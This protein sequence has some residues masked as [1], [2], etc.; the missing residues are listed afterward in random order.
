MASLAEKFPSIAA[1]WDFEKNGDLTPDKV[2]SGSHVDVYW[3]CPVCGQSYKARVCNRTSPSKQKKSNKCPVCLGHVIIPGYNSLKAKFPEIIKREWDYELNKVDPDTIAPHTNKAYY[4]KCNKGHESY[5]SKVNNK[6]NGNGGNCPRCSHQKLSPEFSLQTLRPDLSNEW[7]V[8]A[9]CGITPD[10]VSAYANKSV[11]WVCSKCGHK[12][13]ADIDNRSNGR[14]CP[15]CAKGHHTSFPEQVVFHFI[16]KAFPDAINGYKIDGKEIDVFIPS[17]KIGIEYDGVAYHKSL[18][19]LNNDIRKSQYIKSKGIELIRIRETGCPKF[20]NNSAKVLDVRYTSDYSNL[21][22]ILQQL[23]ENLSDRFGVA[24]KVLVD[25][26]SVREQLSAA[27]STVA[28][29]DSFAAFIEEKKNAGVK[30]RALWDYEKNYPLTPEMVHPFS[31]KKV[32]WICPDNHQHKWRN[33]VKSVSLGYGCS[34]CSRKYHPDTKEWIEKAKA[35]HGDRYEYSKVEFVNA[36]TPVTIICPKHGEFEQIP[37]EHLA[38]K[39]CRYCSHQAFHPLES[40]AVVAPD[41][42][43][44]WD[45]DLN[46]N[47]GFAPETIGIDSTRQFWWHCTNGKPHS[48]HATIA[49]R[50]KGKMQCAV[51][52]G[53]QISYDTSLEYLYP[54]LTK[55]WCQENDRK[56][57]EVSP[58]S[59]YKALWKCPNPGHPKYRT[60]VG[61]RT[62]LHSGCPL[63]AKERKPNKNEGKI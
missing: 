23:I 38:R 39:G 21:Q 52:H 9:N 20:N 22:I 4:W 33:T 57:S 12:W 50:V 37:S 25:I 11:W 45:Y 41:I 53:K 36:K 63:C 29:K 42:A 24:H 18:S 43:S 28:Y 35:I 47:S 44:Q 32:A 34:K 31:E 2:T 46:K 60:M 55:E 17:A 56:P 3:R 61:N 48:F 8:E 13:K 10:Q 51:C 27:V 16:H 59:E 15:E 7:D 1:E 40:L 58:G 30:I 54:E 6:V 62:R 26:S 14:G 5:L 19:K 49:K